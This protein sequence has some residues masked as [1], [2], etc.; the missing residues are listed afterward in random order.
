MGMNFSNFALLLHPYTIELYI[1]YQEYYSISWNFAT[2]EYHFSFLKKRNRKMAILENAL[3]GK[4]YV[5]LVVLNIL[6]SAKFN[7]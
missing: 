6:T 3:A 4:A 5:L 2:K 1:L 7:Q